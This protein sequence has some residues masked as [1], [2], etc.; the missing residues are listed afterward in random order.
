MLISCLSLLV[1]LFLFPAAPSSS[2]FFTYYFLPSLPLCVSLWLQDC[3]V[4]M[5]IKSVLASSET[6]QAQSLSQLLNNIKS[7]V[8]APPPSLVCKLRACQRASSVYQW[9]RVVWWWWPASE[10][11]TSHPSW[12]PA[13]PA[14]P[15]PPA[16]RNKQWEE[17]KT[18]GT[19]Q[20]SEAGN[21]V[22]NNHRV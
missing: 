3:G 19:G 22:A 10:A 14:P 18:R 17:K 4:V 5:E 2:S 20:R 15:S 12:G 1:I 11:A 8:R 13:S 7:C 9:W 21:N 16:E 6:M